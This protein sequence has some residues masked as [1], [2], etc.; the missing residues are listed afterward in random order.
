MQIGVLYVEQQPEA[1]ATDIFLIKEWKYVQ[2]QKT[3]HIIYFIHVHIFLKP[4]VS[5]CVAFLDK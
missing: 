5:L 2:K 1:M 3:V 4:F